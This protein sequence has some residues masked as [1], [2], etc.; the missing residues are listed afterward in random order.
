[1]AYEQFILVFTAI[2]YEALPFVALVVVVLVMWSRGRVR[3]SRGELLVVLGMTGFGLLAWRNVTPAM[4][5]LGGAFRN[6]LG[7][8]PHWYKVVILAC[9]VANPL[10]YWTLGG[11]EGGKTRYDPDAAK[12]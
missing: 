6:F 7:N 11:D 12:K 2:I 1:M 3:P 10:V 8:S 5:L 4:L 9:L